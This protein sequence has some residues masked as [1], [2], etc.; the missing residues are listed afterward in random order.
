MNK[1]FELKQTIIH[2]CGNPSFKHHQRFVKRHLE[3]VECIAEELCEK[4][5]EADKDIVQIMIRLHDYGKILASENPDET[6]L[7]EWKKLLEQIWF[8]N[9][10]I[11]KAIDYIEILDKKLSLDLHDAPI[12]VKIISSAD[13]YSHFIGPF[14]YLYRYENPSK[15]FEQLMQDN[16]KKAQKNRERKIVLPEVKEAVK[17]YYE[18]V[19]MQS[20]NLPEKYL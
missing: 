18:F 13:A 8:S 17:N 14:F 19:L 10:L 1:L 20:G 6:T 16:I 11:V 5:P 9:D 7:V 4:Y 2:A 3:I 12:E 15:P